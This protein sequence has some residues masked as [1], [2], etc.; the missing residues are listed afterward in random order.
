MRLVA[1]A[2]LALTRAGSANAGASWIIVPTTEVALPSAATP[3]L[4]GA[5]PLGWTSPPAAPQ[6]LAYG[7]LLAIWQRAGATY[8]IPWQVLAAINKVESNFGRNMGP[9]SAGAIGWM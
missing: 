3:S 7:D 8:G 6:Q 5:L 2:I 9:S 4:T 1:A